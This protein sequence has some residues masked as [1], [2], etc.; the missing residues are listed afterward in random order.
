MQYADSLKL[1]DNI[2]HLLNFASVDSNDIL[3]VVGMRA[4]VN[5]EATPMSSVGRY[6]DFVIDIC[7]SYNF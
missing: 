6:F 7:H 4:R 3:P 5:A 2:Y 1:L